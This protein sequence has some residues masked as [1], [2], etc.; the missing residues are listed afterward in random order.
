MTHDEQIAKIYDDLIIRGVSMVR[1]TPIE[2]GQPP[3]EKL[4]IKVIWD[5]P[6]PSKKE[7]KALG[8]FLKE[9]WGAY[10]HET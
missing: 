10:W 7:K 9:K 2:C 4:N 5:E 6:K 1:I 8:Q 3:R